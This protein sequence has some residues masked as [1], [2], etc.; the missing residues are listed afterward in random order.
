MDR[1]VLLMIYGALIGVASSIF[2]SLVT[3]MVQLWFERREYERRQNEERMKQIHQIYLPT[4]E[5]VEAINLRREN[6]K[7]PEVPHRTNEAGSLVL[8]IISVIACSLLAFQ[9]NSPTL[10]LAFTA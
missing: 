8:S 7:Q 9:M 5:E 6:G 1:E 10:S 3:F 4:N 2:T